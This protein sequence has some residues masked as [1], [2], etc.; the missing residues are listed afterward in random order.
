MATDLYRDI[1]SLGIYQS[2]S[3]V[4]RRIVARGLFKRGST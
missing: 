1:R 3:E 2:A 4:R